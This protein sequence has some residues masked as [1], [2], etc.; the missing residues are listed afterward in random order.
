MSMSSVRWRFAWLVTC[1]LVLAVALAQSP[2]LGPLAPVEEQEA[3]LGLLP[4]SAVRYAD[5]AWYDLVSVSHTADGILLELAAVEVDG[6]GPLGLLQPIIEI[7]V[8]LAPGGVEELL[9]GSTLGMPQGRGWELAYR[10]TG[11]GA[12]LWQVGEDGEAQVPVEAAAGIEGRVLQLA[13]PSS[14]DGLPLD[15]RSVDLYAIS[16]VHDPF[17]E[18]GWRPFERQASPWAFSSAEDWPPVVD[19]LPGGA[20]ALE[21]LRITGRL[22]TPATLARRSLGSWVW[23]TMMGLGLALG[24]AGVVWRSRAGSSA[25]GEIGPKAKADVKPKA[26]AKAGD[27]DMRR[28]AP[29]KGVRTGRGPR[30]VTAP[31]SGGTREVAVDAAPETTTAEGP[32]GVQPDGQPAAETPRPPRYFFEEDRPHLID[33]DEDLVWGDQ[34]EPAPAAIEAT[35]TEA[36]DSTDDVN[37]STE[38]PKDESR[39][40]KRS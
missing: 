30:P 18:Q 3:V 8:D 36:G 10:V 31:P 23:W 21:A 13:W 37:L 38:A 1:M 33:E 4:P 9:P 34:P 40:A 27:F 11:D 19:V 16:G 26:K 29:A 6:A 28:V 7:Y 39:S 12:W 2:D 25:G 32:A 15:L 14:P 22:P 5:P 24:A 17:R 35:E 20:E